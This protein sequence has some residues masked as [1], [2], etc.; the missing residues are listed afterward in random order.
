MGQPGK[1]NRLECGKSLDAGR[2][3][4]LQRQEFFRHV[5]PSELKCHKGGPVVSPCFAGKPRK[6]ALP[7]GTSHPPSP[8]EAFCSLLPPGGHHQRTRS[9]AW[10]KVCAVKLL[11][12]GGGWRHASCCRVRVLPI[13]S[14]AAQNL[15]AKRL[16]HPGCAPGL[17]CPAFRS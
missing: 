4:L 3:G 9:V 6:L 17:Y 12:G 15:L 2:R 8:G 5:A 1:E 13:P 14:R 16:C 11:W 7:T 10:G